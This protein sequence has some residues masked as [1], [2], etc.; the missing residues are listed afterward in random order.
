LAFAAPA[1]GSMVLAVYE[2]EE[3]FRAG[4]LLIHEVKLAEASLIQPRPQAGLSSEARK[5]NEFWLLKV[6]EL[7][8]ESEHLPGQALQ[9]KPKIELSSEKMLYTE[10]LTG[11]LKS[12]HV[13]ACQKVLSRLHAVAKMLELSR[14]RE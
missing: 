9:W 13:P 2:I 4:I 8:L 3:E 14:D 1:V 12:E 5:G 11:K 10:V 6:A 7:R